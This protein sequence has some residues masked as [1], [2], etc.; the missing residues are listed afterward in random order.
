[1]SDTVILW[2]AFVVFGLAVV[3]I[4]LYSLRSL[5][6]RQDVEQRLMEIEAADEEE[7]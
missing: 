5:G 6:Q 7:E 3:A 2:A 4:L 1:M